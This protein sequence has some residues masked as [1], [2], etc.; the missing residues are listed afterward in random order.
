[1]ILV[2]RAPALSQLRRLTPPSL[3]HI[4]SSLPAL[5]GIHGATG[6]HPGRDEEPAQDPDPRANGHH[7]GDAR[8]TAGTG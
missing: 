6:R 1:M 4:T 3:P 5:P 8:L 7:A 2:G